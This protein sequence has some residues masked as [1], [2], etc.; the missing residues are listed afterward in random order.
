MSDLEILRL[1]QEKRIGKGVKALYAAYP[2]IRS[3]VKSNSGS[4]E[5]AEDLFQEVL[6]VVMDKLVQPGFELTASLKTYLY[7]IALNLWRKEL[8]R[9][10]K[11]LPDA[12]AETEADP[13]VEENKLILAEKAIAQLG[14][15]CRQLLVMFYYHRWSFRKIAQK[16]EFRNDK[17]AKNQ[18]YRCLEKAKSNYLT[19]KAEGHE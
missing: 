1:F 6:L 19:L 10:G 8:R 14:E 9:R 4:R 15:K 2:P 17:V 3:M 13:Q 18:K 7:A 11:P 12:E 16:L 5:D